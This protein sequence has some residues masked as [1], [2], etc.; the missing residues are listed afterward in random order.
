MKSAIL[1]AALALSGA[2]SA[3]AYWAPNATDNSMV[4]TAPG[5]IAAGT[6]STTVPTEPMPLLVPAGFRH[7]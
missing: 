6:L 1:A 3:L 4:P 2:T 5:T 7:P